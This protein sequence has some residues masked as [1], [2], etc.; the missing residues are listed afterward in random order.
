[1][2]EIEDLVT[3]LQY[4]K[5]MIASG[6]KAITEKNQQELINYIYS[7]QPESILVLCRSVGECIM[8]LIRGNTTTRQDI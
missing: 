5:S 7:D 8:K 3:S 4:F 2:I 6:Q 1:M